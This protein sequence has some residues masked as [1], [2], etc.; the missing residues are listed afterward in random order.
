[1]QCR[2]IKK[3]ELSTKFV[4]FLPK[5]ETV[6]QLKNT[7]YIIRLANFDL[8]LFSIIAILFERILSNSPITSLRYSDVSTLK[9][10]PYNLTSSNTN[11]ILPIILS[12]F[13][14]N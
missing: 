7:I 5:G 13:H 8:L 10:V 14:K 11:F 9:L 6:T 1:M 2:L 3:L 12:S 4:L